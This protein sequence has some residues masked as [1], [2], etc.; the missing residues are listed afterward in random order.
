MTALASLSAVKRRRA[1]GKRWIDPGDPDLFHYALYS[2]EHTSRC[3]IFRLTPEDIASMLLL[4]KRG[5]EVISTSG[6]PRQLLATFFPYVAAPPTPR[7]CLAV[8]RML[9]HRRPLPLDYIGKLP[10]L[11]LG[12]RQCGV[13]ISRTTFTLDTAWPLGGATTRT[14]RTLSPAVRERQCAADAAEEAERQSIVRKRRT[15]KE[16]TWDELTAQHQELEAR[17]ERRMRALLNL[18]VVI[19]NAP[20]VGEN[21]WIDTLAMWRTHVRFSACEPST[22]KVRYSG[23]DPEKHFD[24]DPKLLV[25]AEPLLALDTPTGSLSS[26]RFGTRAP[27]AGNVF[28]RVTSHLFLMAHIDTDEWNEIIDFLTEAEGLVTAT[29]T[30]RG[31]EMSASGEVIFYDSSQPGCSAGGV[32]TRWDLI[33][34]RYVDRVLDPATGSVVSATRQDA[35]LV[36]DLPNDFNRVSYD[37][38]TRVLFLL[39]T[40]SATEID[41]SGD[42]TRAPPTVVTRAFANPAFQLTN[43]TIVLGSLIVDVALRTQMYSE[44]QRVFS[45]SNDSSYI[46]S[47]LD[48]RHVDAAGRYVVHRYR[49]RIV[50]TLGT[51]M[52]RK[53]RSHRGNLLLEFTDGTGWHYPQFLAKPL[54]W[55]R[56]RT[57]E[58][59]RRVK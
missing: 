10:W 57:V 8:F 15:Y 21:A 20:D 54:P 5:Y 41:L 42:L 46:V 18:S 51:Q 35:V 11:I 56:D 25:G 33:E 1:D 50:G 37:P 24:V 44:N 48:L 13:T 39:R 27:E 28:V 43:S 12:A 2:V 58:D 38:V 17:V 55:E 4:T 52:H 34:A 40:H 3:I 6:T 19:Q 59:L 23:G 31:F 26:V 45:I 16:A 49:P 32:K 29:S 9:A 47:T 30:S 36:R 14:V 7:E 53:V 22:L